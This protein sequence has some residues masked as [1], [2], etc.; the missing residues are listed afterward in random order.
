[1]ATRNDIVRKARE[2]YG[3][4]FHHQGRMKHIG[5]DCIGLLVGVAKELGIM[6]YDSTVYARVP[7]PGILIQELDSCMDSIP[8]ESALPGDVLVFWMSEGEKRPQHIAIKTGPDTM[9]HTFQHV[10][11]V[12]EHVIDSRWTPKILSLI[13]I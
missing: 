13:H 12:V 1:M 11:R 7:E 5:V 9:I 6:S 8:I 3:T 10:G 2:Y 4:P